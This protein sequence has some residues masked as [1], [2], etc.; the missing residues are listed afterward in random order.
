MKSS[1]VTLAPAS[2][3]G[4]TQVYDTSTLILD[5]DG[6]EIGLKYYPPTTSPI[7]NIDVYF[8]VT[9]TVS[10]INF[11][12][13]VESDSSDTPSGS[14][15]GAATAEFAGPASSGWN[16]LKSLASDTGTLTLNV[17]VWIIVYRSSGGSLDS[18][19]KIS[20]RGYSNIIGIGPI[21]R[22]K[23]YSGSWGSAQAY[24]IAFVAK[25]ADGTL[26]GFPI[27]NMVTTPTV[28][29][30]IY[31]DYYH[32]V[33]INTPVAFN[34][35][36]FVYR[37]AKAGN[38][39]SLV[40][41]VYIEDTL[42]ATQT[43][44]SSSLITQV[45]TWIYFDS[46]IKLPANKNC[47]I[48]LGQES[49]GGDNSNDYTTYTIVTRA[50]LLTAAAPTN[51]RFVYGDWSVAGSVPS[52]LTVSTTELPYIIPFGNDLSSGLAMEGGPSRIM[53]PIMGGYSIPMT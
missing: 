35:S 12:F 49:D 53:S 18:S 31:G 14:V 39:N 50:E 10:G 47:Y 4:A 3:L 29:T 34:L 16:G 13:R 20:L 24:R 42:V 2:M 48:I 32:G 15:L 36:G 28:A 27:H 25:H 40:A 9:G 6:E 30:H 22:G 17:P 1:V 19:N 5:A 33:K 41:K 11:R 23:L 44:L 46:P 52:G 43:I 21:P 51:I 26:G 7:T 8:S 37:L 38:P 45:E